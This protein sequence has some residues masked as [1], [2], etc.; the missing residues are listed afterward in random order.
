M[1]KTVF[2]ATKS[3]ELGEDDWCVSVFK[4][5][6]GIVTF[7]DDFNVAFKVETH[8]HPSL[9]SLMAGRT[10]VSVASFEIHLEREWEPSPFVIG[11]FLFC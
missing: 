4:D 11:H 2:A 6:A 1:L 7:D 8:N 3:E 9:W 5:N 10:P